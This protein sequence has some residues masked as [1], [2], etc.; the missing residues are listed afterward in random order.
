MANLVE[1]ETENKP[2]LIIV[3]GHRVCGRDP[4]TG[5][6]LITSLIINNNTYR[7]ISN[8]TVWI[9]SGEFLTWRYMKVFLLIYIDF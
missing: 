1:R 3:N 7:E 9:C 4:D 2:A 6:R 5:G 8:D